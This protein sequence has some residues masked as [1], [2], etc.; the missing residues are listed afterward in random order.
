ML[1]WNSIESKLSADYFT[2]LGQMKKHANREI[3][4]R[5]TL[6]KSAMVFKRRFD[7]ETETH[8]FQ[9]P[10]ISVTNTKTR[11]N[12][13]NSKEGVYF[14]LH[15]DHKAERSS[16]SLHCLLCGLKTVCYCGKCKQ[17]LCQ[18]ARIAYRNRSLL[19]CFDVLF[20]SY[21]SLP[22]YDNPK[23]EKEHPTRG[24]KRIKKE[25]PHSV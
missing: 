1:R 20:H 13:W 22:K 6:W 16:S 8:T 3:T 24:T 4:I 21:E 19:T 7:N 11:M 23:E 12:A 17:H 15:G 25:C 9:P 2:S 18:V 14:R 5:D 10:S